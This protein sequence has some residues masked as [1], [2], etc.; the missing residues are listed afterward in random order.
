MPDPETARAVVPN[1]PRPLANAPLALLRD[2][3]CQM[4]FGERAALEGVLAQLWPRLSVEIG[5]AAGGSLERIACYSDEVH[6]FD[7]AP[8]ELGVNPAHVFHHVGDS[9]ETLAPWLT[10]LEMPL[11]FA[12]V[13]GDHTSDGVRK[14]LLDLLDA[15]AAARTVILLHDTANPTVRAGIDSIDLDFHPRVV[16]H[17]LDMLGGYEFLAGPFADQAWGGLGLIVTGDRASDGYGD[18]PMQ[19]LYRRRPTHG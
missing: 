5:S 14:D 15:P 19:T 18:S 8:P 7:L 16:Y 3:R 4:S 12:L 9:H 2:E 10:D 13:D 6:A 1:A 17:E 11:D